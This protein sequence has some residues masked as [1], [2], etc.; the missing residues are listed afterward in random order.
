MCRSKH[1][2]P[3]INFEIINSITSCILLVFLLS[4]TT[5][6]GSMNIKFNLLHYFYVRPHLHSFPHVQ[7]YDCS[8]C[9]VRTT[10][11][12]I[13]TWLNGFMNNISSVKSRNYKSLFNCF[14][15]Y[16][17]LN[18]HCTGF[19]H[20]HTLRIA[21]LQQSHNSKFGIFELLE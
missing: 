10:N 17:E 18:F 13:V 3:S 9:L 8:C 14:G 6:P 2:E 1:V 16:F 5:M 12:R 20:W 15:N 11:S 19:N 7:N 21:H 4:H